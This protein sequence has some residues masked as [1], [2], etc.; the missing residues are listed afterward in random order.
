MKNLL[1]RSLSSL[2]IVAFIMGGLFFN[3]LSNYFL[4]LSIL[5]LGLNEF[6]SFVKTANYKPNII[7]GVFI[8]ASIYTISYFVALKVWSFH[9]FIWI[10]PLFS[11]LLIIELYRKKEQPIV[12]LAVSVLGILYLALPLSLIH[13]MVIHSD[14]TSG[15]LDITTQLLNKQAMYFNAF[16]I[17]GYF[18]IQWTSDTGAYLA[19][20]TMGKHRLFER[21]SP[22]KSWEGAIGGFVAALGVAFLV[23]TIFPQ[24]KLENWIVISIIINVFGVYGDLL[25]SLFKRSVSVK[26]SGNIIPGH[27]GILDRFDS[28]LLGLPIVFFYLQII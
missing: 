11:I 15:S 26:D 7:I 19:G 23:H 14:A 27:G 28:T 2:F 20:V 9:A 3:S 18:M 21:I 1:T 8:A 16:V 12:N 5:V 10:I 13:F 22:K 24:L 25:E 4:F 17:I 6:Y